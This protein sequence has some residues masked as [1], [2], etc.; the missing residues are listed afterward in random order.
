MRCAHQLDGLR[1]GGIEEEHGRRIAGAER[2]LP[3]LAQQVAHVHGHIAK[4]DV[5]RAG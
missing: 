3:H 1:V 4:V 5:H 2:L